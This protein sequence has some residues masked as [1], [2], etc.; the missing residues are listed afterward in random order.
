MKTS[1][2]LALSA[3]G[4]S[5]ITLA[6]AGTPLPFF[7]KAASLPAPTRLLPLDADGGAHSAAIFQAATSSFRSQ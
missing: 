3:L 4:I 5:F 7:D 1:L 6:A 2:R